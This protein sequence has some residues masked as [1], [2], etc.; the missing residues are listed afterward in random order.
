[1]H[2]RKLK[3]TGTESIDG[4]HN[5]D[6]GRHGCRV[7]TLVLAPCWRRQKRPRY[8]IDRALLLGTELEA[9]DKPRQSNMWARAMHEGPVCLPIAFSNFFVPPRHSPAHESNFKF[10]KGEK[11]HVCEFVHPFI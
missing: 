10:K 3:E 6:L 7:R 9:R 1:M 5:V 2:A 11:K 4:L 8:R